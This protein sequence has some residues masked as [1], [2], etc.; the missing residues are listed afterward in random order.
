MGR[1]GGNHDAKLEVHYRDVK[2]YIYI[3]NLKKD[4][5]EIHPKGNQATDCMKWRVV[6]FQLL[7]MW[8]CHFSNKT[9]S[10][11]QAEEKRMGEAGAAQGSVPLPP[12][13]PR[14]ASLAS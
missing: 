3:S 7:I 1:R 13:Q 6:D 4:P 9:E 14:E 11:K 2:I 8:L 10:T 12:K 5:R